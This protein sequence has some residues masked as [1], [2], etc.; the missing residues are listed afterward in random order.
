MGNGYVT[1]TNT[2]VVEACLLGK[3]VERR[4]ANLRGK[5]RRWG[6]RGVGWGRQ[7][8]RASLRTQVLKSGAEQMISFFKKKVAL[9]PP[10]IKLPR[11]L[12]G[13]RSEREGVL[14]G[15]TRCSSSCIRGI[16]VRN[17]KEQMED[18]LLRS[19]AGP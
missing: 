8:Q 6:S 7:R 15:Q 19:L 2:W 12:R 18:H 11:G 13:K 4:S 17:I 9:T 1:E 5:R 3:D 10:K 14:R 16:S